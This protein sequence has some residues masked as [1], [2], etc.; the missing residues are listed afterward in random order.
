[1]I[2]MKIL[3]FF[4]SLVFAID[5]FF[6]GAA[7]AKKLSAVYYG[8]SVKLA[9]S[10]SFEDGE[11]EIGVTDG[12]AFPA[13]TQAELYVCF[14]GCS[15]NGKNARLTVTGAGQRERRGYIT[16][17]DGA[18]LVSYPAKEE[19]VYTL[20]L[21]TADKKEYSFRFCCTEGLCGLFP[22][23]G[24][25][26][27]QMNPEVRELQ[28]NFRKGGSEKY[29]VKNRK[30]DGYS[31]DGITFSWADTGSA[32]RY[33]LYLS[34]NAGMNGADVYETTASF[35]NVQDLFTDT[36]YYWQVKSFDGDACRTSPVN[37]FYTAKEHRTVFIDGVNNTRDIGGVDSSL[38]GKVRQGIVYRG[39]NIDNITEEGRHKLADVFGVHT[40][41]DLRE[42]NNSDGKLGENSKRINISS[43]Y[44]A[45]LRA[46]EGYATTIRIMKEFAKPENYP[47]YVHCAIGRDRTGCILMILEMLLGV[48][49]K[50]IYLDYE[51]SFFSPGCCEF[52][53]KSSTMSAFTH[54]YDF[55]RGYGVGT[56]ARCAEK[57]LLDNGMTKEEINSIR[58]ICLEK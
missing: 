13:G 29:F 23:N 38:G 52:E 57:F 51:L 45:D 21:K 53:F 1:M 8:E 35:I 16:A 32:E 22:V 10:V 34:D 9:E 41:F 25:T 14:D 17:G 37:V 5:S 3:S 36:A 42:E 26:V 58:E 54:T 27:S 4:L 24:E 56:P 48:S 2:P 28:E 46:E 20:T 7:P 50:D 33:E 18:F 11:I 6:L 19:G 55:V 39:A 40:D 30:E 47:M 44:Y 12:R 31:P 15:Q 43:L 49:K